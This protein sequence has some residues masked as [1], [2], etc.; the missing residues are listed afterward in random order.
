MDIRSARLVTPV[1]L[2]AGAVLS[3]RVVMHRAL[4]FRLRRVLAALNEGDY[5]PMLS[6]Y[7]EDA[8]LHFSE[9][10][11]RWA[12]DHRTRSGIERF[13]RNFVQ[14]GLRGEI[15]EL[16]FF[17]PPWRLTLLV[18]FDD[19]AAGENGPLMY[20]NR[21]VLVLKTRWGQVI[22]QEDFFE[23]TGRI[24][25]FESTLRQRGIEAVGKSLRQ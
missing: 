3:A 13:L 4:L 2:G 6:T 25:E 11:H 10:R 1:A 18:R 22:Q 23:D 12:G 5:R 24:E 19:W 16:Y 21:T 8:V 14:A 20:S 15:R 9:G 7:A 17:G